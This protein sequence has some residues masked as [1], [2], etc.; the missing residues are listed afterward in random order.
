MKKLVTFALAAV[1]ALSMT[2]TAFAA[3]SPTAPII[4]G[5]SSSTTTSEVKTPKTTVEA[6][7]AKDADGKEI[8]ATVTG[9]TYKAP[10]DVAAKALESVGLKTSDVDVY[11]VDIDL[12][13]D[14]FPASVTVK[15]PTAKAGAKVVVLHYVAGSWIEESATCGDGTVTITGLT[16]CSPFAIYVQ[17]T[18]D[19]K[20]NGTAATSTASTTSTTTSNGGSPKTGETAAIPAATLVCLLAMAGVV[21]V[22]KKRRA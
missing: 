2:C 17:K 13:T 4:N 10:A 21:L 3:P 22:S 5:G 15:I 16:S 7:T 14:S 9:T 11:N 19:N 18:A 20:G 12:D 1:T 8:K 6:G